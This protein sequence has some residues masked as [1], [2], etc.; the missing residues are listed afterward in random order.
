MSSSSAAPFSLV[1]KTALITGASR[2]IGLAIAQTF[3]RAGANVVLNAR[4]AE[5]LTA[6]TDGLTADGYHARSLAMNAGRVEDAAALIEA[7]AALF[8]GQ[9]GRAHV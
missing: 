9:I 8:G 2:G 7:A 4:K 5:V 1:G 3:A 6:A